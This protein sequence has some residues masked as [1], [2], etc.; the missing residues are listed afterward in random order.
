MAG[1]G[2]NSHQ[3]ALKRAVSQNVPPE[4]SLQLN[5]HVT[6]NPPL[7][8]NKIFLQ[9]LADHQKWAGLMASVGLALTFHQLSSVAGVWVAISG[10]VVFITLLILEY[11]ATTKHPRLYLIVCLPLTV[12]VLLLGVSLTPLVKIVFKESPADLPPIFSPGIMRL[13]PVFVRP[14]GLA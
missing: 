1:K 7:P 5:P 12:P 4:R 13:S 9:W 14:T 2:G 8:R 11:T 3:R 10:A 6:P